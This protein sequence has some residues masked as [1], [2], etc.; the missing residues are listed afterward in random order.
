MV[1]DS[2]ISNGI[3]DHDGLGDL[4]RWV[5]PSFSSS[6]LLLFSSF[7]NPIQQVPSP[8]LCAANAMRMEIAIRRFVDYRNR[9]TDKSNVSVAPRPV[10]FFVRSLESTVRRVILSKGAHNGRPF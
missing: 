4:E 5:A 3:A 2:G 9:T 10:G 1:H 8:G 7:E 6:A